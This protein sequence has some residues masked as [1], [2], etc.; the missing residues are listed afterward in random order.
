MDQE[1]PPTPT[2]EHSPA[3][4]GSYFARHWRGELSLPKSYW[5][6]GVLLF[7]FGCNLVLLVA[8]MVTAMMCLRAENPGLAVLAIVVE[9]ALNIAA[10]IWALVG[11][12]R[13]A[14]KYQGPRFWS[15]LA[16]VAISLGVVISIGRLG[17]DLQFIDRITKSP[18]WELRR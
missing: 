8:V 5:I 15:I 4:S 16:R 12:W 6:N 7:G 3:K 10:Y 14:T 1:P 9:L 11:T 18:N 13:S 17:Q 2:E